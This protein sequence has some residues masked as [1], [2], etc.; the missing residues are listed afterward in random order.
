M[1]VEYGFAL[2]DNRY[3]FFR[4]K[5]VNLEDIRKA[6]SDLDLLHNLASPADTEINLLNLKLKDTIRCDLKLSGLHRDL[7]RLIRCSLKPDPKYP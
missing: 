2:P 6:A 4:L 1:I 3:D 7:L 5:R